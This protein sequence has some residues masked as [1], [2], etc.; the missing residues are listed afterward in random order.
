[1]ANDYCNLW[2]PYIDCR[3]ATDFS[4]TNGET[5]YQHCGPTAI[6]TI[7]T[8]YASKNNLYGILSYF[9][10]ELFSII[11][12]IG[13]QN[14][15]Y[16]NSSCSGGT[17]MNT[18]NYFIEQCFNYFDESVGIRGTFLPTYSNI[19]NPLMSGSLLYL[20]SIYSGVMHATVAYAY[21]RLVNSNNTYV[22]FLKV[23]DGWAYSPRYIDLSSID[24]SS[25]SYWEVYFYNG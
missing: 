10:E 25:A 9:D 24:Y 13:I 3:K 11:A 16:N 6:L 17:P 8:A 15:Y 12:D 20:A 7:L 23:A 21:T 5:Y 1:M 18:T 14:G 22:T 19:K 2:E 4:D